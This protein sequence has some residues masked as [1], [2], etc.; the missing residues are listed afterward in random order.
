[1]RMQQQFT[2]DNDQELPP[3]YQE[4][5]QMVDSDNNDDE[6][7]GDFTIEQ[8]LPFEQFE[9]TVDDNEDDLQLLPIEDAESNSLEEMDIQY[10]E[11]KVSSTK[12][13][14]VPVTVVGPDVTHPTD[15]RKEL[16]KHQD[17]LNFNDKA[18]DK[19]EPVAVKTAP[20]PSPEPVDE[21][22]PDPTFSHW[23]KTLTP[24]DI[25][26]IVIGCTGG[27]LI[28]SLILGICWCTMKKRYLAKQDSQNHQQEFS[29]SQHPVLV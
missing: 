13:E 20:A 27:L 21:T 25:A 26:A 17:D 29:K 14:S 10:P 22:D 6:F 5:F 4:E 1:M 19:P 16:F 2:A 12:Q 9:N 3:E 28:S 8:L 15:E 11:V 24:L 7:D 23:P 18:A